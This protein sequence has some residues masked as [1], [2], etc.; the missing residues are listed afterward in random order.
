MM[1]RL[2]LGQGAESPLS[3]LQQPKLELSGKGNY[4]SAAR[5]EQE[6]D[7]GCGVGGVAGMGENRFSYIWKLQHRIGPPKEFLRTRVQ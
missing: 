4:I 7:P 2:Q 6:G 1:V 3:S 5:E